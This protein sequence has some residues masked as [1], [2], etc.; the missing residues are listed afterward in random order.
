M[1]LGCAS[2]PAA[3]AAGEPLRLAA[4]STMADGIRVMQPGYKTF[5]VVCALPRTRRRLWLNR[6]PRAIRYAY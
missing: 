6:R 4:A 2:F 1:S 5:E 3:L